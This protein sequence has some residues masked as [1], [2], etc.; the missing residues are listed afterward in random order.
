MDVEQVEIQDLEAVNL[1]SP[2][3]EK[4]KTQEDDF[5]IPDE[6]KTDIKLGD[7]IEIGKNR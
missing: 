3:I 1:S 4:S 7:L 5:E 2:I 6:I